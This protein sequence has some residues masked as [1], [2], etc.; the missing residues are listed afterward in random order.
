MF[1]TE[2]GRLEG[3]SRYSSLATLYPR[4]DF[5]TAHPHPHPHLI[6]KGAAK[7]AHPHSQPQT[8]PTA[9]TTPN[10]HT[11]THNYT[12]SLPSPTPNQSPTSKAQQHLHQ[13]PHQLMQQHPHLTHTCIHTFTRFITQN[14]TNTKTH[15]IERPLALSYSHQPPAVKLSLGFCLP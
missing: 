6:S 14:H 9:T 1:K 15:E 12:H 5:P 7:G 2:E 11:H 4:V 10:I 8:T 3:V 13:Y